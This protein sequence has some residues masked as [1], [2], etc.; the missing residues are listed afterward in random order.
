MKKN[1]TFNF[2]K[3]VQFRSHFI[4]HKAYKIKSYN[5]QT[6][7]KNKNDFQHKKPNHKQK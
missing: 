5:A 1:S 4:Y 2:N 3:Q 6:T 7:Q